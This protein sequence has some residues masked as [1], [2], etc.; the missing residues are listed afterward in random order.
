MAFTLSVDGN[1][2]TTV[3][4]DRPLE[5]VEGK[6]EI[7]SGL[8]HSLYG[9]HKGETRHIKVEPLMAYGNWNPS[10]MVN[11]SKLEFPS[12][13]PLIKGVVLEVKDNNGNV[14]TGKIAGMQEDQITVDFNHPLAGKILDF[15]VEIID[16]ASPKENAEGQ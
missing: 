16:I 9:L 10:L 2:I 12:S 14:S 13:I 1:R 5:F 6:G 3:D 7:I 4:P 11:I 8:E 15:Q